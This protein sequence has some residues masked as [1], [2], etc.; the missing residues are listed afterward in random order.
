MIMRR[1][2]RWWYDVHSNESV[3]EISRIWSSS[4]VERGNSRAL[5][6]EFVRESMRHQKIQRYRISHSIRIFRSVRLPSGKRRYS[7]QESRIRSCSTNELRNSWSSR[8]L[9][10]N[11]TGSRSQ[12]TDPLVPRRWKKISSKNSQGSDQLHVVNSWNSLEVLMESRIS[13]LRSSRKSVRLHRLRRYEIMGLCDRSKISLILTL[14]IYSSKERKNKINNFSYI[15]LTNQFMRKPTKQ[16]LIFIWKVLLFI[17]VTFTVYLIVRWYFVDT[18]VATHEWIWYALNVRHTRNC[19]WYWG[20][21][22]TYSLYFYLLFLWITIILYTRKKYLFPN[23]PIFITWILI[24]L[25]AIIY[26]YR[27]TDTV[28]LHN[29][30]EWQE[31]TPLTIS[32]SWQTW[33][34][35]K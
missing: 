30:F 11:H 16:D 7:S 15:S 18:C 6:L 26:I 9:V 12:R 25:L 2:V 32:S 4:M 1:I 21:F 23:N 17:V 31:L 5:S 33:F 35:H 22:D 27:T 29:T 34:S 20:F 19:F 13:L 24:L 3:R 28:S 8:R 14:R 10:M